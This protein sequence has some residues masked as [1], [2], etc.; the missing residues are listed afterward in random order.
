MN[1]CKI[2]NRSLFELLE[3]HHSVFSNV[4]YTPEKV[5]TFVIKR[6]LVNSVI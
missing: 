2:S 4:Y 6:L 3:V 5:N 1:I